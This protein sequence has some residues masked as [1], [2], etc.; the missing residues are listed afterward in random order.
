MNRKK[1]TDCLKPS[2]KLE[3]YF[4]LT[5]EDQAVFRETVLSKMRPLARSGMSIELMIVVTARDMSL[6]KNVAMIC[7][8]STSEIKNIAASKRRQQKGI[9]NPN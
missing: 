1:P 3:H 8:R 4:K 7:Q 9:K 2:F 5:L 6:S